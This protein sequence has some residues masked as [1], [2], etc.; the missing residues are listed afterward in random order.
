MRPAVCLY[1][2][3]S[4]KQ[5]IRWQEHP[6][7]LFHN[8]HAKFRGYHFQFLC[9]DCCIDSRFNYNLSPHV[10]YMRI[11]NILIAILTQDDSYLSSHKWNDNTC[12]NMGNDSTFKSYDS[13]F[14]FFIMATITM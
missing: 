11:N 14:E 2:C 9:E 6:M 5:M 4:C 7:Y 1:P 8:R 3:S 10:K 13:F 12:D